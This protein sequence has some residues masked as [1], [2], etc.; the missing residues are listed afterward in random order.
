MGFAA[1]ATW[2][3][4]QPYLHAPSVNTYARHDPVGLT[5]LPTGRYLKPVGRHLAVARWPY[6]LAMSPD[7]QRL[8]VASDGVGQL[9]K[10]WREPVPKIELIKPLVPEGAKK[11]RL[12]AG[13]ADF[14]PDGNTL[15]WSGGD[16]G[17]IYLFNVGS[18]EP[19]GEIALNTELGGIRYEDSYAVDVKVSR[20]GQYLY[21]ADVANFRLAVIA[22]ARRQVIGSVRV[23]RYPYALAVN[24]SRV[25]AANIGLFEYRSIPPT[26]DSRYDARGLTIPPF[27]YPSQ[28][29][30]DGREFEG[31][32]IPGLGDPNVPESF[33]VWGIDVSRPSSPQV[34]SRIKTGLL[35]GAPSDHGKTVGGSAPNFLAMH[36]GQ[37]Y[38]SNGNN[39]QIERLDLKHDTIALKQR[40]TPSPLTAN[41]R[42]VG[43]AGMVVSPDGKRLYVAES[44]INAIAVLD[45]KTLKSSAIFPRP[46]IPTAWR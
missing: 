36:D 10:D 2:G 1:P 17:A 29:A 8:F 46:G 43:P 41:L 6:G 27:G 4:S 22:V 7:G 23:G 15:Y 21:C 5:I 26:S 16:R 24:G 9:I 11:K 3:Q 20:D 44:G 32:K 13:G 28:E 33:S 25:Y 42:G 34:I 19:I 45:A 14:S 35:V 37:L 18:R 31:R 40:L 12:N 39:D 30:R 38:V